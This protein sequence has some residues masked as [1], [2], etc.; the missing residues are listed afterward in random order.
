[1]RANF[2]CHEIQMLWSKAAAEV[3][4]VLRSYVELIVYSLPAGNV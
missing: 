1:M 3:D 2:K 4:L